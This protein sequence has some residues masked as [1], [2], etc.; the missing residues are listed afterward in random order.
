M[1]MNL[2]RPL[3]KDELAAIIDN[4]KTLDIDISKISGCPYKSMDECEKYCNK[5]SGCW[6]IAYAND[7]LVTY[8][9]EDY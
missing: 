7:I 9:G 8:T 3:E 6:T 1:S 5:Y 2:G 4:G